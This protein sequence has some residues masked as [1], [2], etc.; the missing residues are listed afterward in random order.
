MYV[1]VYLRT[2]VV[3]SLPSMHVCTYVCMYAL[4]W[5]CSSGD[6]YPSHEVVLMK[7]PTFNDPHFYDLRQQ[8]VALAKEKGLKVL[9]L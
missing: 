1:C 6:W 4:N 5:S 8:L 2:F 3:L 9:F 7:L